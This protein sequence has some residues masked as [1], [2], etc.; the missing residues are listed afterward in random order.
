MTFDT[1]KALFSISYEMRTKANCPFQLKCSFIIDITVPLSLRTKI[2]ISL[3]SFELGG[4]N[5]AI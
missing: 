4:I 3:F 5:K 2:E 1:G